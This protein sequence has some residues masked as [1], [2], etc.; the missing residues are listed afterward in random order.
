MSGSLWLHS[1][2]TNGGTGV[3]LGLGMAVE[4]G[5]AL[6]LEVGVLLRLG[7]GVRGGIGA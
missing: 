6:G 1:C 5:A 2:A 7:T 3:L 4:I